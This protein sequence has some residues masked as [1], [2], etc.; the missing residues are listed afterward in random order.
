MRSL[1]QHQ[2]FPDLIPVVASSG[3]PG[4]NTSTVFTAKH[5]TARR[6]QQSSGQLLERVAQAASNRSSSSRRPP[7][8]SAQS[9]LQSFAALQAALPTIPVGPTFRQ[10]VRATPWMT[11]ISSHVSSGLRDPTP[12][13]SQ[14]GSS[15]SRI[16]IH[17]RPPAAASAPAGPP[18]KLSKSLFPALPPAANGRAKVQASG[19]QSLKNILGETM[20]SAPAWQGPSTRTAEEEDTTGGERSV[21]KKKGK[22]KQKQTLFTLGSFPS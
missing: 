19:N 12:L 5:S 13:E 3:S 17:P 21:G 20:P 10:N 4:I 1:Q 15:Q 6:S 9:S 7:P 8:S 2:N 22:G 18:P 14:V 11:N 16:S